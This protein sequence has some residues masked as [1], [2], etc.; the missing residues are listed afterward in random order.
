[1]GR[2]ELVGGGCMEPYA[3]S[4][5]SIPRRSKKNKAGHTT[6]CRQAMGM[7]V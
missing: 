5:D 7:V 6:V 1:M 2:A 3:G 4:S